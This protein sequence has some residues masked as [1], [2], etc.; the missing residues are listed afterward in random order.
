M[1]LAPV[2]FIKAPFSKAGRVIA[3][4]MADATK[5]SAVASGFNA[6]GQAG[7]IASQLSDISQYGYDAKEYRGGFFEEEEED[8]PIYARQRGLERLLASYSKDP[9]RDLFE[10]GP[11]Y[12]SDGQRRLSTDTLFTV[13]DARSL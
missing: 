13:D 9:R 2:K 5:A 1:L 11:A 4:S 6:I 12:D 8:E 3:G 7:E 10:S